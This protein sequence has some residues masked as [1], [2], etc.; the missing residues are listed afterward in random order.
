[1]TPR[2]PTLSLQRDLHLL[3]EGDAPTG[4]AVREQGHP[5]GPGQSCGLRCR[6]ELRRPSLPLPGPYFF[7]F[8]FFFYAYSTWSS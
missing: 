5:P 6:L 2:A 1:M 8:L 3:W 4:Q 7:Y